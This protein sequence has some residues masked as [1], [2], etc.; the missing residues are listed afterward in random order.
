[1][2]IQNTSF[3]RLELV[4]SKVHHITPKNEMNFNRLVSS[5]SLSN[6]LS[7][8]GNDGQTHVAYYPPR[9]YKY[10][11]QHL[12]ASFPFPGSPKPVV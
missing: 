4:E 10:I 8:C 1:M 3:L 11:A 12:L 9:Q 2:N 6:N 7:V 5:L